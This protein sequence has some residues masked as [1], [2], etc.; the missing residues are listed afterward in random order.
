MNVED[1]AARGIN[2]I[3]IR[4]GA[5]FRGTDA[6]AHPDRTEGIDAM[7]IEIS[8]M[9]QLFILAELRQKLFRIAPVEDIEF[10]GKLRKT[11]R[12]PLVVVAFPADAM[13]P[14][15]V[16]AFMAAEEIRELHLVLDAQR[17]SLCGIRESDPPQLQQPRPP[18]TLP[19]S[20][21]VNR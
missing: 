3:L 8:G 21:F 17:V 7:T 2:Q 1:I 11:F 5:R 12:E 14:P 15:L 19:P 4:T 18:L 10:S 16:R 6:A 13:T 20:A 9:Q